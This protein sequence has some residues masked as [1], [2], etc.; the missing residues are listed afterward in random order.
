MV[1]TCCHPESLCEVHQGMHQSSSLL[2]VW[3]HLFRRQKLFLDGK[4]PL[5]LQAP[6][7]V[8]LTNR[9]GHTRPRTQS[10]KIGSLFL[11]WVGY[12]S[13]G[14]LFWGFGRWWNVFE[15]QV[16]MPCESF[17]EVTM[18]PPL[19]PCI[20]GFVSF[21]MWVLLHSHMPCWLHI[22]WLPVLGVSA[23]V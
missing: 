20:G 19:A 1:S 23:N 7:Q 5:C 16:E 18:S 15:L 21:L 14:S 12:R 8:S 9:S 22:I 3:V 13:F 17:T 2:D 4:A 11:L 6:G 10:A